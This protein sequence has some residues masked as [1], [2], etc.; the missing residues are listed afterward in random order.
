[1]SGQKCSFAATAIVGPFEFHKLFD[2]CDT[3][4]VKER[5][6]LEF[7]TMHSGESVSARCRLC[8]RVF[9]AKPQGSEKT[10]DLILRIRE[11]FEKHDCDLD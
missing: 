5:R 11:L 7:D 2:P 4:C 9:L 8:K 6:T 3:V 10:D 1:M